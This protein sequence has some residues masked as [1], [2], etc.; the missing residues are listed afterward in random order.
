[1]QARAKGERFLGYWEAAAL[2]CG[3]VY[4]DMEGR[5]FYR[6]NSQGFSKEAFA[7]EESAKEALLREEARAA[8]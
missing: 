6:G 1:M 5:F 8:E 7:T 4:V 3:S 2:D